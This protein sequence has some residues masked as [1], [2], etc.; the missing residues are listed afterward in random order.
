MTRWR[1]TCHGGG[2]PAI[3]RC[4]GVYVVFI[5]GQVKYVGSSWNL[6]ERFTYYRIFR[7]GDAW[8]TPWGRSANFNIKIK[9]TRRV[10]DWL[11]DEYRLIRRLKPVLNK[12]GVKPN[13]MPSIR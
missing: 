9:K 11:M 8:Q 2:S 10:G 6:C 12:V 4:A 1:V 5:D 13:R 7:D 3:P